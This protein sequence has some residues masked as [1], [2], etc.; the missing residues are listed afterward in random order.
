ME[1]SVAGRVVLSVCFLI[2]LASLVV[3]NLPESQLRRDLVRPARAIAIGTSLEQSWGVFAPDPRRQVIEL[4]AR[5]RFADGTTRVWHP[6]SSGRTWGAYRTYRWRKWI[7]NARS[8]DNKAL[9][10]PTALF[11]ARQLAHGGRFPVTVTL[12]RR[13][14]DLPPPG[15]VHAHHSP[16]QEFSYYTVQ[17]GRDFKPV[18]NP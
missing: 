1:K 16:W 9:W 8:D 5:L 18:E 2:V 13:W 15:G 14:Y 10:A 4:E 6:P 17:L 11:A 12:V 7:E 3:V